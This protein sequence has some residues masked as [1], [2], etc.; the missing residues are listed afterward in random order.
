MSDAPA[1]LWC[2]EPVLPTEQ[3]EPAMKGEFV[4]GVL[5]ARPAVRHY[6]CAARVSLGSWGHQLGLCKC[7]G[8]DFEDPPHLTKRDAAR[9][10]LQLANIL[11]LAA[12]RR[13]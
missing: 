5:I 7:H 6:E 8:G 1:C 10:A 3:S 4:D 2:G 11:C 13:R 9:V 12:E